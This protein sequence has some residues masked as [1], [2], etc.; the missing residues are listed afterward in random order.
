MTVRQACSAFSGP[1]RQAGPYD[2]SSGMH[3]YYMAGGRKSLDCALLPRAHSRF[4]DPSNNADKSTE[5][6]A[7]RPERPPSTRWHDGVLQCQHCKGFVGR[8][9]W[10]LQHARPASRQGTDRVPREVADSE[11][12]CSYG[13]S[14]LQLQIDI[15]GRSHSLRQT[16]AFE[17]GEPLP[18]HCL[19]GQIKSIIRRHLISE[20]RPTKLQADWTGYTW[21]A[22]PAFYRADRNRA[23][24]SQ[25]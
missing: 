19:G 21:S 9:I 25:R 2:Q 5:T 3:A 7:T 18:L 16:P 22:G 12:A 15:G 23:K 8:R 4:R 11:S 6:A 14:S 13:P 10:A 17:W 20:E 1:C 24:P